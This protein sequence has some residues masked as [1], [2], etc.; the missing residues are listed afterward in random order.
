MAS[1]FATTASSQ[2]EDVLLRQ[3]HSNVGLDFNQKGQTLFTLKE[4]IEMCGYFSSAEANG[5]VPHRG[6]G[7]CA[8]AGFGPLVRILW[9]ASDRILPE[10]ARVDRHGPAYDWIAAQSGFWIGEENWDGS[11]RGSQTEIER[12]V[13][14]QQCEGI[15]P[16]GDSEEILSHQHVGRLRGR[17]ARGRY[18]R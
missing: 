17:A 15:T 14:S 1:M 8:R 9:T 13:R 3:Q 2:V 12:V 4:L 6:L 11:C 7:S 10:N 18:R 16:T 5:V